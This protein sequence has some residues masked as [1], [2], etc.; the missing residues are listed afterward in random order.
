MGDSYQHAFLLYEKEQLLH[1]VYGKKYM[2]FKQ[3]ELELAQTV[4]TLG[5]AS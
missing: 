4:V 3:Q 5:Y 1:C 2:S